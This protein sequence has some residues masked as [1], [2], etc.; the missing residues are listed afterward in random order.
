MTSNYF[1]A[2]VSIDPILG[3]IVIQL[4]PMSSNRCTLN[5]TMTFQLLYIPI[6][7][8]FGCQLYI[9]LYYLSQLLYSYGFYKGL[10]P[11]IL[12]YTY[13]YIYI[14][15]CPIQYFLRRLNSLP[16]TTPCTEGGFRIFRQHSPP[17]ALRT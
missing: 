10:N 6:D 11:N 14:Y 4:V 9:P 8:I 2:M 5:S 1:L 16:A 7:P 15:I 12:I 3:N 17:V 13:I